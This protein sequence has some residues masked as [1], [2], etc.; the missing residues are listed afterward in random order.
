MSKVIRG[1]LSD[2]AW[3]EMD[4]DGTV[5]I[6]SSIYSAITL[7][8]R[9]ADNLHKFFDGELDDVE[10]YGDDAGTPGA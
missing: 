9:E 2:I 3:I 6:A 10:E 8:P 4:E 1:N 5:T 7:Y